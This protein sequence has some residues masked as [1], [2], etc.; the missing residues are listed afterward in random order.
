[1]NRTLKNQ[2]AV[3]TGASSGIGRAVALTLAGAGAN[4][5]LHARGSADALGEAAAQ[6][7]GLGVAAE[8][9]LADLG[10][11]AGCDRLIEA[12]LA[13]RPIDIWVHCAGADVLTGD[14][15]RLSF[16]QKLELLWRV[17]VQG[18]IRCC[19][20]VGRQMRER[21]GAI[22]TVGWDQAAHGMEGE[23]GEMFATV[24]AAVAAF[25]RSLAKSLAPTV[26]VN[27]VAPGWIA[28][29][30]G[31]NAPPA[32]AARARREALVG[33]WGRPEDVANAVLYL[34]SPAAA[35]VNAQ[36]LEVNGGF[37]G[38]SSLA[39]RAD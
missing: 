12:A 7:R 30:W 14:A 21:G 18:A 3:V 25:S 10:D 36:V 15:A 29:A 38:A 5:L 31:Q 22:V 17:D 33:R 24:K 23:S 35:F 1:M 39:D 26:R 2:S 20:A 4:V 8:T 28:T 16:D 34:V 11:P 19:R 9:V 13:W 6:C 27:C 37:S 32:W